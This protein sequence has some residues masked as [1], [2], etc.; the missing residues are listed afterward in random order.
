MPRCFEEGRGG[1]ERNLT[2]LQENSWERISSVGKRGDTGWHS[3]SERFKL[4][5]CGSP[6]PPRCRKIARQTGQS[7]T[8]C[9]CAN[10][11]STGQPSDFVNGLWY[12]MSAHEWEWLETWGLWETL[13]PR[14]PWKS[15]VVFF[16][17]NRLMTSSYILRWMV[18]V[19]AGHKCPILLSWFSLLK[20]LRFENEYYLAFACFSFC[21]LVDAN[22]FFKNNNITV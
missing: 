4:T 5:F 9:C 16:L 12:L 10:L 22:L 2:P 15:L 1:T 6:S 19:C 21:A 13:M 17:H 14:S 7:I 8:L 3:L 18:E 20:L 11:M